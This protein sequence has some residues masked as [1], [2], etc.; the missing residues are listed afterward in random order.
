MVKEFDLGL[1]QITDPYYINAFD[2]TLAYLMR[3]DP[4]RLLAGFKAVSEGRDPQREAGID[5]TAAGK[6][7][8]AY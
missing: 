5:F 6:V 3:L 2:Q 7:P 8:G 1:V 4:D